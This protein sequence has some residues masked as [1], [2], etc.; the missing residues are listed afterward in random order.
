MS[1]KYHH[2]YNQERAVRKRGTDSI[3]WISYPEAKD[4]TLDIIEY[5]LIQNLKP[6]ANIDSKRYYSDIQLSAYN[7]VLSHIEKAFSNSN[8]SEMI[9]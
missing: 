5:K 4:G 8:N 9:L 3:V 2:K 7:I 6:T 1:E